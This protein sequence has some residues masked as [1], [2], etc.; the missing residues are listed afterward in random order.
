[1]GSVYDEVNRNREAH[2]KRLTEMLEETVRSIKLAHSHMQQKAKHVRETSKSY[3][4]KFEHDLAVLKEAL[5]RDLDEATTKMEET[6]DTLTVRMAAAEEALRQQR[7]ARIAHTEATLGPIRDEAA[8]LA[9]ELKQERRER[10]LREREQEKMVMDEA[11][12]FLQL[13]DQE[14][15]A[16]E[17]QLMEITRSAEPEH[18]RATK[19]QSHLEKETRDLAQGVRVA[20]QAMTKERI[21]NQ[22]QI[23]ECIASFV[24]KF[25][26][27]LDDASGFKD[28][29][30]ALA[31]AP[32]ASRPAS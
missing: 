6:I 22:H 4:S 16:R 32:S 29:E 18:Q 25:R 21:E 23:V 9:E 19:R 13:L 14:K 27:H 28:L 15:F 30:A 3:T 24:H 12:A 17:Q 8:H 31:A 5:H 1:M 7:E 11:E 20:H 10:Q 2:Q 26:V